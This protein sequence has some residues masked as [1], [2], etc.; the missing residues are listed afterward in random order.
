MA[1]NIWLVEFL[2]QNAILLQ[3]TAQLTVLRCHTVCI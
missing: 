3:I 2:I 1:S